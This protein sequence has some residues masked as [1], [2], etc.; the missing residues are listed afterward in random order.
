M[1]KVKAHFL[2]DRFAV[3]S[4]IQLNEYRPGY[5]VTTVAI[6]ENHLNAANVVQGG[7]LFTLGDFASAVAVNAHGYVALSV[8]THIDYMAAGSAG[9]ITAEATET[10]RSRRISHCEVKITNKHHTLLATMK[11]TYY[12]TSKENPC[13]EGNANERE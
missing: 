4:G 11:C 2:R 13:G 1:D 7:L 5:A 3:S 12:I 9:I 10:A 8:S 6:S